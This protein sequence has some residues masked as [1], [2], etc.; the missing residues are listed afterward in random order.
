MSGHVCPGCSGPSK[1]RRFASHGVW[2]AAKEQDFSWT[3]FNSSCCPQHSTPPTWAQERTGLSSRSFQFET[4]AAGH[5]KSRFSL[6][7]PAAPA[8]APAPPALRSAG[9]GHAQ[10]ACPPPAP[11]RPGGAREPWAVV[12]NLGPRLGRH[13]RA[14]YHAGRPGARRKPRN[15][16]GS[17]GAFRLT[18]LAGIGSPRLMRARA[19]QQASA[20]TSSRVGTSGL[21]RRV[22]SL[23]WATSTQASRQSRTGAT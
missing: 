10:G 14:L 23:Q 7:T 5:K 4:P 12:S 13:P 19:S 11:L 22:S 9:C 6:T 16:R 3:R 20:R 17:S 18:Q 15:F 2:G 21:P 8:I 1:P